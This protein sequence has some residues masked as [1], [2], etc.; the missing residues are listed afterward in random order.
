MPILP[1]RVICQWFG[2]TACHVGLLQ[3]VDSEDFELGRRAD[4]AARP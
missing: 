4:A 1:S 2:Q 3:A